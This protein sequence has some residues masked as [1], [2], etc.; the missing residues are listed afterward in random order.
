MKL[1]DLLFKKGAYRYYAPY[2]YK[3][4][5]VQARFDLWRW[6]KGNEQIDSLADL[7]WKR[8]LSKK[9]TDEMSLKEYKTIS[10]NNIEKSSSDDVYIFGTGASINN[11]STPQWNTISNSST[12]GLNGFFIHDFTVET[13]FFE[14]VHHPIFRELLYNLLLDNPKRSN[15]TANMAG[16]YFVFKDVDYRPPKVIVPNIYFTDSVKCQDK[17]LLKRIVPAYFDGQN[18]RLCHHISNLDTVINYAVLRGHKNLYLAGVDLNDDGYFWDDVDLPNYV[19]AR[20][21][22]SDFYK[23]LNY[24][25]PE[26]GKHAT[27]AKSVAD[28]LGCLTIIEYLVYL[29][30]NILSELGVQLHVCNPKSLLAEVLPVH[31]INETH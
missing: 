12:I 15:S 23:I 31:T 19:R 6:G 22:I 26:D 27:S 10:V 13:Y 3:L 30:K 25:T 20:E 7:Y 21:Y 9:L 5:R 8:F 16:Y 1:P 28:K 2:L 29:Q 17:D 4:K 18:K 14:F 24:Q 11:I